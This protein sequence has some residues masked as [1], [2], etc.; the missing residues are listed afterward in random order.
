MSPTRG[1][2]EAVRTRIPCSTRAPLTT[3]HSISTRAWITGGYWLSRSSPFPLDF[4]N[5]LVL[6]G[7]ATTLATSNPL[8]VLG[9]RPGAS[10]APGQLLRDSALNMN[11]RAILTLG[12]SSVGA[13]QLWKQK[14]GAT[15]CFVALFHTPV[16]SLALQRRNNW[17]P[18]EVLYLKKV[19]ELPLNELLPTALKSLG[20]GVL[21]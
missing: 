9:P 18:N 1:L 20:V 15:F 12:F 21:C 5:F 14:L 7:N 13:W 19:I 17:I 16:F 11:D 8:S 10:P 2:G 3:P 6:G 4:Q